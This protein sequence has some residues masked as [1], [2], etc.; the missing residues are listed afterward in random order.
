MSGF[1]RRNVFGEQ[2]RV[3]RTQEEAL[4]RLLPPPAR[5]VVG[6]LFAGDRWVLLLRKNRPAWQAGKLNGPGGK[7]EVGETFAE[8][9]FREFVEE[10]EYA[11]TTWEHFATLKGVERDGRP[12]EVAFFR[13]ELTVARGNVIHSYLEYDEQPE[14]FPINA[15]PDDVLPKLRF[16]IPM[17]FHAQREAWPYTIVEGQP[18]PEDVARAAS[19]ATRGVP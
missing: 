8:A 10:V 2:P 16:L 19:D 4:G 15:L 3:G 12:Y 11:V 13:A 5:Y 18:N 9:M 17:A 14:W 1:F 6:F 7:V